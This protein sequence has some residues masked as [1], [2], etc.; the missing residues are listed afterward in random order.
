MAV[1][2]NVK[3]YFSG[4]A[5]INGTYA[6]LKFNL[7]LFFSVSALLWAFMVANP[8]ISAKSIILAFIYAVC[9][10][11]FQVSYIQALDKGPI[12]LVVLIANL[13]VVPSALVGALMFGEPLT[14][15]KLVGLILVAACLILTMRGGLQRSGKGGM[16]LALFAMAASAAALILQRYHQKTEV[17]AERN[18]FLFF[19]YLFCGIITLIILLFLRKKDTTEKK[20]SKGTVFSAVFSG[21]ALAVYQFI[22]VFLSGRAQAMLMYPML[23]GFTSIVNLLM[24]FI[25][26]KERLSVRQIIGI[27]VGTV[28]TVIMAI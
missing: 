22:L 16:P 26:F 4:K 9:T 3:V 28:A 10:I 27:I 24:C 2:A 6:A 21:V 14:A 8:V 13:A 11:L 12:A 17:R 25:I 15:T 5:H 18:Q 1:M 20:I 23:S 7:I 19:A